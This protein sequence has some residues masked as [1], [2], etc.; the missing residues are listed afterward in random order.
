MR[1]FVLGNGFDLAHGFPTGYYQFRKWLIENYNLKEEYND[2]ELPNFQTNYKRLESYNE[3][4]FAEFFLHLI[5][6]VDQ[7]LGERNEW[8]FFEEDLAKLRWELILHN[9][10]RVYDD[11]GCLT[12]SQTDSRF[13]IKAQNCGESNHILRTLFS[14][15]II[16]VNKLIDNKRIKSVKSFFKTIFRM[17]DK[18]L[19]FNYTNTLE[20]LYN[21]QN[22]CH[23]HGDISKLQEPVIGHSNP[24]Y[25]NKEYK[26]YEYNAFCIF[27]RIY[28]RYI[29]DTQKQIEKH[30][31][32]FDSI[33]EINEIYFYGLSFG[34]VD[35]PYFS[36]IFEKCKNIKIIY[37]NVYNPNEFDEK[38]E[39]LKRCGAKCKIECWHC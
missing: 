4:Q 17:D 38:V 2:I 25:P 15:W 32:F 37:L 35:W 11:E 12:F 20:K 39:I 22:V 3:E 26:D 36:Y 21:I 27:C 7:S 18:Y 19:T 5:D 6:D 14:K 33:K 1:L 24:G 13:S 16:D 34:E 31:T 10:D 8:R 9:E 23:I 28:E 29:K 30:K